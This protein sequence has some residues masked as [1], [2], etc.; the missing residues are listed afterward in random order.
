MLQNQVELTE[1]GE[2]YIFKFFPLQ[3]SIRF[4][5][6]WYC[7]QK[8]RN[9]LRNFWDLSGTWKVG[10]TAG[11]ETIIQSSCRQKSI[12]CRKPTKY[13]TVFVQFLRK[14]V[15]KEVYKVWLSFSI[16]DFE[17]ATIFD[18][19]FGCHGERE[20]KGSYTFFIPVE[21]HLHKDIQN[22]HF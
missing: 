8:N 13:L 1:T 9:N 15:Y 18:H 17:E 5:S 14:I 10:K 19:I 2:M 4:F 21:D 11:G 7:G 20:T 3:V 22:T 12:F 6:I 16:L